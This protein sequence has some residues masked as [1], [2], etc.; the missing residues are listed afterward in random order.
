MYVI[1]CTNHPCI[2]LSCLPCLTGSNIEW[3]VC[4]LV[5]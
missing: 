1:Q 4:V 5:F 3:N 2:Y